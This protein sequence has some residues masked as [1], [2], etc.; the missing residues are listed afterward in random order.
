MTSLNHLSSDSF[1]ADFE[2]LAAL[3]DNFLVNSPLPRILILIFQLLQYLLQQ[4]QLE[5]LQHH[6]RRR[7][8]DQGSQSHIL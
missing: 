5:L 7:S 2:N 6:L 4:V 3:T 1:S 8:T